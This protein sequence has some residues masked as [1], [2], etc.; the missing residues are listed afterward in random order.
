MLSIW[1]TLTMYVVECSQQAEQMSN[2]CQNDHDVQYLVA[3]AI[4][5]ILIWAPFLRNPDA[6]YRSAK[7]VEGGHQRHPIEAHA[8][9]LSLP[10]VE[11]ETVNDRNDGR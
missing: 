7:E 8:H 9:L 2:T 11:M 1:R 5:V 10:F 4:D 6:I 3:A